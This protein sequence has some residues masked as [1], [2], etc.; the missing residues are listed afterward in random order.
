MEISELFPP[1]ESR[2]KFD[3]SQERFCELHLYLGSFCNREC[4][5]CTVNGSLKGWSAPFTKEVLNY[6]MSLIE[7]DGNLKIYGGEPT[8]NIN[9]ILWAMDHLRKQGF[10][11]WLTIFTNGILADRLIAI[12]EA[13]AL[14]EAVLNYSILYG[15]DTEAIPESSKCRLTE[16]ALNNPGRIFSSHQ[17]LLPVG[18]G[19]D[20]TRSQNHLDFG[21][22]C[23][24]CQPVLTTQ[25]L[26]HACPFA[27]EIRKPHYILGDLKTRSDVADVDV[28]MPKYKAFRNWI[29]SSLT[30]KAEKLMKH[31]CAVCTAFDSRYPLSRLIQSS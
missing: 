18:R 29:D 3:P 23:P 13:D 5:F 22:K 24:R 21:S 30:P 8:L 17:G 2:E 4:D 14:T 10:E 6:A 27:V 1:H 31:P 28:I 25:G 9:N 19:S 7:V 11:G 26:L 15:K 12:L 20:F 16:Y